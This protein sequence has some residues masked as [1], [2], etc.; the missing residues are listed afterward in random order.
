MKKRVLPDMARV[1]T[2][3]RSLAGA[4]ASGRMM[5]NRH[6]YFCLVRGFFRLSRNC[7]VFTDS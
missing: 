3:G 1:F 7:H 5:I 6:P 4:D 2:A